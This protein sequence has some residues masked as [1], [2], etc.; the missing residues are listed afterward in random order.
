ML[1]QLVSGAG[2]VDDVGPSGRANP[3]QS[4][5]NSVLERSKQHEYLPEVRF[6]DANVT[7]LNKDKIRLR[8]SIHLRH[9]F[10][11]IPHCN[12]LIRLQTVLYTGPSVTPFALL[13]VYLANRRTSC[14]VGI[15]PADASPKALQQQLHTFA[16]SLNISEPASSVEDRKYR[17]FASGEPHQSLSRLGWASEFQQHDQAIPSHRPPAQQQQWTPSAPLLA[18][19][20]PPAD[21]GNAWA[22]CFEQAGDSNQWV[23]DFND[24]QLNNHQQLQEPQHHLHHQPQHQQ[25]QQQA[26][27]QQADTHHPLQSWVSEYQSLQ[28]PAADQDWAEQYLSQPKSSGWASEFAQQQDPHSKSNKLTPEELKRLKGPQA[29]DPLDDQTA[30]SWVRQFNETADQPTVNSDSGMITYLSSM[31]KQSLDTLSCPASA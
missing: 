27:P 11:G 19:T 29:D 2:C 25:H 20:P 21:L 16:Q 24:H 6:A 7:E 15:P 10:P 31:P 17:E 3:L 8:S 5:Y 26:H 13:S 12:A 18:F 1:R 30:L 14:N 9:V 23:H 28:Q 22:E 4:F